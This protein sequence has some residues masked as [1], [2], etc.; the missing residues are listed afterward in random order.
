MNRS[1]LHFRGADGLALLSGA[2]ARLL[3]YLQ[4]A[5]FPNLFTAVAD[6]LAGYLII[7]GFQIQWRSLLG[8][9]MAS[10]AIYAAGCVLNDLV[11]REVDAKE[12]PFR[13]IPSGRVSGNRAFLMALLLVNVGL[14]G[15]W[16]AGPASFWTAVLLVL[17]VILYDGWAKARPVEGP[18]T[19]ALC[20]AVNLVLGMSPG[21][22][23]WGIHWIFPLI[24]LAYVSGLTLLSR[25]EVDGEPGSRKWLVLSLWM[26][27]VSTILALNGMKLLLH[28]SLIYLGFFVLMTGPVLGYSL[29]K[30][31]P[32]HTGRAVKFMI[33]AI[34]L[35][36][37]VY[38]SGMRGGAAA[39]L[40]VLCLLPA[41][42]FSRFLYVT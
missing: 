14:F 12:R 8:L 23:H 33:L 35:L 17:L 39:V 41:W 15:A 2:K 6:V 9:M 3:P 30:V 7:T 37:A 27:T 28:H 24:T 42:L 5:R 11:D 13:P 16:I 26:L 18:V 36:D 32:D 21:L 34:P 10:S 20:R 25:F 4:L 29:W 1:T 22:A 40:V 38:V 19:M 31:S